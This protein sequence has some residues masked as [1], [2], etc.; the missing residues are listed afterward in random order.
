MFPDPDLSDII[1]IDE[2]QYQFTEATNAPGIVYAEIGR[3]AK[4]YRISSGKQLYA[5]KTF[6]SL[7]RNPDSAK[8]IKP[9]SKYKDVSGLAVADRTA[10]IPEKYPDLIEQNPAFAYSI[11]MPWVDGESWFNHV[12]GKIPT[13][14]H[15]SLSLA[16]AFVSVVAAL[17][18]HG[19][20]HC[21]LSSSNFIFSNE[22]SHVELIDIEDLFGDGLSKP[23]EMPRG[24]GGYAPEWIRSDG[25]WEAGAD[26]FPAAI[27]VGEMI[28]WQ[29]AAVRDASAGDSYFADGEFGH[30][31]QRFRILSERLRQVHPEIA[32]LFTA[33]WFARG[34]EECPKIAHWMQS[35][36]YIAR[37]EHDA[38]SERP[39]L[40][41][42]YPAS[43]GNEATSRDVPRTSVADRTSRRNIVALLIASIVFALCIGFAAVTKYF[44]NIIMENTPTSAVSS[45]MNIAPAVSTDYILEAVTASPVATNS[46]RTPEP[47]FTDPADFTL[48]YFTAVWKDRDY[49]YLWSLSTPSFQH[50]DP[51]ESYESYVTWWS[52]VDRVDV[53]SVK[54]LENDGHFAGIRVVVTF[55]LHDG[56]TLE[57]RKYD[58]DLIYD[59]EHAIWLFD[60]R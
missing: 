32:D 48:W 14:S 29:F 20:A 38:L 26:R 9:I 52:S 34:I 27:L 18:E 42:M 58:Y 47:H 36:G 5:L 4:V 6:K 17:E 39:Q 10:I 30:R 55:Y 24:T 43:T 28:G 56:Q 60:Y 1:T 40:Y 15:Q 31:S 51:T 44:A 13:D 50:R 2:R 45:N 16:Y 33:V 59:S 49:E 41:P 19:L 21:D 22:F 25:I 23:K 3:K 8:N 12:A 54:V 35:L 11:L 37:P 53:H 57:N 7:Y 46:P